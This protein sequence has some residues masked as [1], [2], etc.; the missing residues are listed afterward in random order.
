MRYRFTKEIDPDNRFDLDRVVVETD[1]TCLG[2]VISTFEN[3][4]RA[5]GYS[6]NGNLEIVEDE[7]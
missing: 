6:F 5:C 2:D 7:D 4:L 3:F 1:T